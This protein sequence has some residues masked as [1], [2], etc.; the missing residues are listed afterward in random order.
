MCVLILDRCCEASLGWAVF[1]RHLCGEATRQGLPFEEGP[2]LSSRVPMG[3]AAG[4]GAVATGEE[5]GS[6][7]PAGAYFAEDVLAQGP[8]SH[9]VNSPEL[10]LPTS[11]EGR[12][13]TQ[14]KERSSIR[15]GGGDERLVVPKER[16]S[17]RSGGLVA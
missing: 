15:S 4:D 11:R 14:P 17:I 10:L 16:S 1:V 8:G 3:V 13:S 9:D 6:L 2:R 12:R 7:Q 5:L